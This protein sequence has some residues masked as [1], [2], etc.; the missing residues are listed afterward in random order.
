MRLYEQ[1]DRQ[2][3]VL[4]FQEAKGVVGIS[5]LKLNERVVEPNSSS[6][7]SA[8]PT[9]II[10]ANH[11]DMCRFQSKANE[12]YNQ[13]LGEINVLMNDMRRKR[14]KGEQGSI[15]L[16]AN[17]S[18]QTTMSSLTYSLNDVERKSVAILAQHVSNVAEYK[19]SLPDRV[20]G[21]CCWI[22]SHPQYRDWYSQTETCLL[23]ITGYPGSG[24][25]VLSAYLLEYFGAAEFSLGLR[26]T[27]CYFFC[28]AKIEKQR[29][30]QTILRSLI[31]QLITRRR[32]LVKYVK[33]AY[34]MYGPHF[35][36]NLNGLWRILIAIASDKRV[37][38]ITVVV[39]A[40]DECEESTRERFLQDIVKLVERSKTESPQNLCIK[41]IVTSRPTSGRQYTTKHV[42]IDPSLN[43]EMEQ[44]LRLVIR[45]KVEDISQR[46]RC[47]PVVKEYLESA[48]YSKADHTF[49]WV[50]LVLHHLEKSFLASQKDFKRI[51]DELPK[52]L[53]ATYEELLGDI[54]TQ[55]QPLAA[56]LLHFIIGSS[57][58]LT[59]DEMR[60]LVAIQGSHHNLADVDE[61]TQ[62][63]I[64]E[65]LEGVLGSLVRIWDRR[66]YLV[67]QS[68]KEYLLTLSNR[69]EGGLA[70]TYGINQHKAD[71]LLA[72]SCISYLMLEDFSQDL[73]LRD[74]LGTEDS[75]TSTATNPTETEWMD[76][77]WS[78][79]DLEETVMFKDP[80]ELETDIC[81]KL[82]KDYAFFDY[83]ARHWTAHFAS[84]SPVSSP[85]LRSSVLQLLDAKVCRGSNWLRYYWHH[86]EPYLPYPLDFDPVV[87]AS[88]FGHTIILEELLSDGLANNS[89]AGVRGMYWASRMGH[90][91]VLNLLLRRDVDPNTRFADGQTA[92]TTATRF[93]RIQVV[94]RLLEDEG[95]IP[96][97]NEYRVNQ[98]T[99]GG[100][101][102]LS[103]AASNGFLDI[104]CQLLQHTKIQPEIVDSNQWTPLFWSINGKHL[105]VFKMLLSHSM[106]SVNH[107]D[108]SGRNVLSWAAA[109]GEVDLVRILIGLKNLRAHD[110]D[111]NGRTAL[112][113]AAGNGHLEV[114]VILRRSMRIDVAKVDKDGRNAISWAC[115]G[116]HH[117]V[118]GYLIKH[119]PDGVDK[120]DVDGWTPLAW[121][122]FRQ[123]P[124]TVK[125]LL[126]SGLVD[127]NKKD[128]NGRSTLSFAAGYGY[129]AIVQILLSVEGIEIDSEDNDGQTPLL[130][131]LRHPDVVKVLQESN[132]DIAT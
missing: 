23:W 82:E 122:T 8:E 89:D 92:L 79:F 123:A 104:V 124:E 73:F 46:T 29:D 58:P 49:L 67:H 98:A 64:Q 103:I 25:T 83:A 71:L 99:I 70:D 129:L 51:I 116:A 34:E 65:T 22:L 86:N 81:E 131:A 77:S 60:I 41:F 20:E 17:S 10:N 118:V 100:R 69:F 113:W 97:L 37:G 16:G 12:G 110:A 53:S 111:H 35:D 15:R 94:Q 126:R 105:D 5:Y 84:A 132:R 55:Y 28:D 72:N 2:F 112:S 125:T 121:A 47:K 18:S 38:P 39:D 45:K 107:V 50:T 43:Q 62:P 3:K 30:S 87:S 36:Q 127:A 54:S 88:Y 101:T 33:T 59:L 95:L 109:D 14:T 115:S 114:T 117:S 57:R 74:R 24:K 80:A 120:P 21:T 40:I 27:L 91:D 108:K 128:R 76:N 96:E 102:P 4:T 66:I 90:C 85:G 1:E 48:L 31:H 11:M 32:L 75:P 56:K 106:V 6:I 61:E 7:T 9:Q 26:S 52:T 130:H 13:I 44:D 68:L 93:N 42:Q 19:S 63:N 78:G 119:D